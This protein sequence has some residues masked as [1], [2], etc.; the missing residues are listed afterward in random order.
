MMF[1]QQTSQIRGFDFLSVARVEWARVQGEEKAG[2]RP[3][4]GVRGRSTWRS[5]YASGLPSVH[6]RARAHACM[7]RQEPLSFQDQ[8]FGLK[9]KT[10]KNSS[11]HI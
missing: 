3:C 2:K 10:T 11:V 1:A 6:V 5:I 4:E 8:E 9:Q 7:S